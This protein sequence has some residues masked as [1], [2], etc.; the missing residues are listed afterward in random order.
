MTLRTR[1]LLALLGLVAP[2]LVVAGVATFTS[3]RSFLLT[4][5]DQQLQEARQ[6]VVMVLS[7]N[8]QFPGL[9]PGQGDQ[10]P[11]LPPGTYGALLD[12]SGTVLSQKT[13]SYGQTTTAVPKL[14]SPLPSAPA[15]DD[16]RRETLVVDVATERCAVRGYRDLERR[17]AGERQ[18]SLHDPFAERP[19]TDDGAAPVVLQG[20]GDDLGGTR[21]VAVD[22][23]HGF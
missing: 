21:R 10:Q 2:G 4:R 9:G 22:E 14:P 11:N 3:L 6:P 13:I 16:R 8:S 20:A 5:V 12:S 17:P 23:D 15:D 7:S 18:H 1:L 19:R